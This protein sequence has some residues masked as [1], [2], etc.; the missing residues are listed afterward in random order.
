MVIE[1][2]PEVSGDVVDEQTTVSLPLGSVRRAGVAAP[3][4]SVGEGTEYSPPDGEK[5]VHALFILRLVSE[6]MVN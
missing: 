6:G 4:N 1:L 2:T 5:R 3:R